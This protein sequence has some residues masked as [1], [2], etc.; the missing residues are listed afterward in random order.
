MSNDSLEGIFKEAIS[1]VVE[2]WKEEG[3]SEE[4]IVEKME[5]LDFQ[6]I[7]SDMIETSSKY[8]VAYFKKHMYEIALEEYANT[9]EFLA[10]QEQ[11]WGK[12]FAA[13]QTMYIMAVESAELF[14]E[15]VQDNVD[16]SIREPKKYTYFALQHMHGRVCQEFLEILHLMRLGFADCA[17]A[18]WRSM[19][20]LCCCASFILKYGED[21]AK[22]YYDVSETEKKS[23][24]W[25]EGAKDAD[26]NDVRAHT[27][28]DIQKHSNLDPL[29]KKQY[30]LACL[31]NHASPQGTFKR[32]ANGEGTNA[33]PVGH[34]DYGIT[35]PAEHSAIFLSLMTRMFTSIFPSIDAM[36]RAN[37][38]D[39]W[40]TVIRD[41]YF[42]THDEFFGK[43]KFCDYEYQN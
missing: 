12:C 29:W 39:E 32:L 42:S 40:I 33:I 14:S 43:N 4:E 36:S 5:K 15:Y 1:N 41:M 34:S 7:L 17:Y 37:V 9:Q 35:T 27:F 21:V 13:S 10:H 38:L 31:I 19:Y 6:T 28:A 8:T 16:D 3:V 24:S 23:Y 18:R 11:I 25:L 26:G 20:E 2:E 30:D 22:R